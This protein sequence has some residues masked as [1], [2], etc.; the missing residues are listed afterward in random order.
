MTVWMIEEECHGFIGLASSY[1]KAIEWL[2][3]S[4]WL[5]EDTLDNSNPNLTT[6][7]LWGDN[8]QEVMKK[9]LDEMDLE[10]GMKKAGN[11]RLLIILI[12]H[13]IYLFVLPIYRL[14][15]DHNRMH[16]KGK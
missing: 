4:D 5:T 1:E 8:W 11:S 6:K 2:I 14:L 7:E 12:L 3:V 13:H 15:T 9:D 10:E 16:T